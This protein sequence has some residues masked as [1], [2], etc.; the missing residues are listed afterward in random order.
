MTRELND[1]KK[2]Y[3]ELKKR[4]HAAKER[5]VAECSP[6]KPPATQNALHSPSVPRFVGGGFSLNQKAS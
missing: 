6:K 5:Q 4:E 3:F 2:K 1:L